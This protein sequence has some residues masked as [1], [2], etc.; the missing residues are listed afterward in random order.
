MHGGDCTA[1]AVIGVASSDRFRA[2][3]EIG[4]YQPDDFRLDF[5]SCGRMAK[6]PLSVPDPNANRVGYFSSA[7]WFSW[8]PGF[9]QR[10]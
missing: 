1:G 5:R 3:L 9:S 4:N 8:F 7:F 6:P 10:S 2:L